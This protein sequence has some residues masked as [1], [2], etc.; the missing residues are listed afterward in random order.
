LEPG[1]RGA[2]LQGPYYPDHDLLSIYIPDAGGTFDFTRVASDDASAFYPLPTGAAGYSYRPPVTGD[3]G[4]ETGSLDDVGMAVGPI[5]EMIRMIAAT[6]VDAIDAPYIHA[7]L[8]AR[9]G[10]LVLEEYFHGYSAHVP[11][12]TRSASKTVTSTL[13]GLASYGDQPVDV[14]TP[15]Y[16]T[17][18]GPELPED[19]DPRKKHM[20]MKHLLTMT[21]GLACDDNNDESPGSEDRMQNQT[22]QPDW[23]RFTL[24]LPMIHEPGEHVAYCSASTNAAGGVLAAASESW[25]P[26]LYQRYFA[27]PMQMGLYHMNLMPNGEAYGGG[28]LHILGRDF[29]KMGQIF[30]DGGEWEERKLLGDDW[31]RDAVSP[32]ARMF[33]QGYGYGWWLR[34]FPYKKR[35]VQAYYAGGNGGQYVIGIPDL[36][37]AIVFFGGNYGQPAT[38]LIK[39]KHV[40]DYIIRSVAEGAD[41]SN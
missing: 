13:V 7:V 1:R 29:L 22:D 37:L 18:Y 9:H 36:D 5:E 21:P 6:P 33:D 30:L 12:E 25:I 4:W 11:H 32:F 35:T 10:K 40:P 39:K 3:D 8:I 14:E 41:R 17:I 24:D 28:G 20:T 23:V 26:D 2:R 19:L 15:V 31:V 38:H 16:S 34:S 27:Q